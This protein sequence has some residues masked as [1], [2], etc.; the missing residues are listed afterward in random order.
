MADEDAWSFWYVLPSLQSTISLDDVEVVV[1]KRLQM[2][3]CESPSFFCSGYETARDVMEKL[4][5]MELPP[6]NFG[7]IIMERV[8]L[9][10]TYNTPD[11]KVTLLEVYVDEFIAMINYLRCQHLLHTSIAMLHGIHAIFTPPAVTVH[12]GFDPITE[13]KLRKGE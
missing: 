9:V 4:C 8:P 6:H 1:P 11:V 13:A 7:A 2:G 10:D 5:T 12:N 3:W